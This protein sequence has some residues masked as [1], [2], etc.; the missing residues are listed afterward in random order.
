MEL[1]NSQKN[2]KWAIRK[3][4]TETAEDGVGISSMRLVSSYKSL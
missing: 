2:G 4:I 1:Q 3:L